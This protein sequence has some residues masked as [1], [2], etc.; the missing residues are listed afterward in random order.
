[1]SSQ[2][3]FVP[4]LPLDMWR[5]GL[6]SH[7]ALGKIDSISPEVLCSSFAVGVLPGTLI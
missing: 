1:M 2:S 7:R 3:G 5:G 4:P 6:S